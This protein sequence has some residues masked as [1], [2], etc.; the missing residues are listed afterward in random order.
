MLRR[1]RTACRQQNC[2][3]RLLKAGLKNRGEIVRSNLFSGK[4]TGV[5]TVGLKIRQLVRQRWLPWLI[6]GVILFLALLHE[7]IQ[8]A[9]LRNLSR[10]WQA[11]FWAMALVLFLLVYMVVERISHYADQ[12]DA[13]QKQVADAEDQVKRA[14]Q[15]LQ[16][17]F[18]ISQKFVDASDENEI[19][20]LM[21]QISID[22]AEASGAAYVPLD[23]HGQP[24]AS[25]RRGEL[26]FPAIGDWLEYLASPAVRESCKA[27]ETHSSLH[28]GVECPLLKSPYF[29]AIGLYCF[30]LRR[31]GREYGMLN[32]FLE[33]T[34]SLDSDHQDF[35]RALIDET[36]LALEGVRLRRR[37]LNALRQMQA[38]RQKKDWVSLVHSLVE[39]VCATLE[40]DFGLA[41][42]KDQDESMTRVTLG[43]YP[44]HAQPFVDGVVQ[45][46]LATGEPVMV[47][48]VTGVPSLEPGVRS[49]MATPL[50]APDGARLGALLV[51]NRRN[52]GFHP[53]QFSLLQ[54][55]ASQ[56][57]LIVQNAALMAELEYQ[58]M[59]AERTR[60]AREIHDGLAQTLGFLKLQVAQMQ[61]YLARDEH[62]RLQQAIELCYATLSEAYQDARQSIDG[63]RTYPKD[64]DLSGWLY[65]TAAEFQEISG[66]EV[67]LEID[68]LA[69]ELPTEIQAQLIRIV[70]E[71]LSNVRKHAAA[72]EVCIDWRK[73]NGYLCLEVR[74]NGKG[75]A[76][77][78]VPAHSRH[79]LRGMRERSDLIGADFQVISRPGNGTVLRVNLPLVSLKR[80]GNWKSGEGKP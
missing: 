17:I 73:V 29:E 14:A 25:I 61:N 32:L 59:I 43:E 65:Q 6:V 34:A 9:W 4:I 28:S 48:D 42:V 23:E 56:V 77:E 60:L 5:S 63:L 27:C 79:G 19:I 12:Q 33:D 44:E 21:L 30:P 7:L 13:L 78:D 72:D 16:A 1:L 22:L 31:G 18:R 26:P 62:Q 49:L 57:A 2:R 55:I 51:G 50:L 41:I 45:S 70:Q 35:L 39:D 69:V 53:R 36:A 24:L 64:S 80:L 20:E 71:A 40:S 8:P 15:R 54:T 52:E 11:A 58:A 74:D 75:F 3:D 47:G 76:P 46:V 67:D 66:I 68:T 10:P 38:V 37:E